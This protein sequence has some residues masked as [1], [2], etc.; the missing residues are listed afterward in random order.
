MVYDITKFLSISE[1][2]FPNGTKRLRDLLLKHD[3]WMQGIPVAKLLFEMQKT[4]T[5]PKKGGAAAAVAHG[6]M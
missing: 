1:V 2:Y 4:I 3:E 6:A 5:M